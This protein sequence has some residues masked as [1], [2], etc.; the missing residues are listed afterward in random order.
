MKYISEIIS[1]ILEWSFQRNARKQFDKS[2]LEYR[3]SDNT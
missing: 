2:M 3:D 1:K